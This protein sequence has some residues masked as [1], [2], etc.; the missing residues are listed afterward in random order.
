M[1]E[2]R[3]ELFPPALIAQRTGGAC[4]PKAVSQAKPNAAKVMPPTSLAAS[5]LADVFMDFQSNADRNSHGAEKR[6]SITTPRPD[7]WIRLDYQTLLCAWKTDADS[8]L[9]AH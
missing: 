2:P 3:S 1:A 9:Q 6:L 8:D 4:P 5:E 7:P